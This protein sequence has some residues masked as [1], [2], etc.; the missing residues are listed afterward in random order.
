[1]DSSASAC[2]LPTRRSTVSLIKESAYE[3]FGIAF[4]ASVMAFVLNYLFGLDQLILYNLI[5]L[6]CSL[7]TT[8]YKYKIA[9]D[10][11]YVSSCNCAQSFSEKKM[12]EVLKV[13][14]HK[15]G[16]M[17]F[18]VPNSVFG[19][20]FYSGLI[21]L[22]TICKNM[23][24]INTLVYPLTVLGIVVSCMGSVYLWQVMVFEIKS[25]C[26]LCMTIHATNF[27]ALMYLFM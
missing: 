12:A 18:N 13:V 3:F 24:F 25:I 20:V 21:L 14:S 7:Q 6:M 9:L 10:P 15:K 1:M 16:S 27:L 22:N 17:L 11:S 26:I 2:K 4:L 19:I 5:G 8:Y 23:Y